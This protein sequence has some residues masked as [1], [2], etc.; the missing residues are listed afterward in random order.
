MN[1][2]FLWPVVPQLCCWDAT[3]EK[4][5]DSEATRH[6]FCTVRWL[7]FKSQHALEGDQTPPLD[8]GVRGHF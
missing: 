8:G 1:Q 4:T 6:H 7:L 5:L 3:L 2:A